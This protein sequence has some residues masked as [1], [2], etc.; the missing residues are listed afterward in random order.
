MSSDSASTQ[1][2]SVSYGGLIVPPVVAKVNTVATTAATTVLPGQSGQTFSLASV[3]AT[4]T[5]PTAAQGKGCSYSFV[6][7]ANNATTAWT[8]AFPAS[9]VYG[10]AIGGP[11]NGLTGLLITGSSNVLFAT[12]ALK[13]DR[14]DCSCDG[15]IWS[16]RAYGTST[17]IATS[18]SV[19]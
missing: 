7:L 18:F 19:S 2:G 10:I 8:I 5:M 11:A 16:V 14:L 4:V 6:L 1:N 15:T 9:T 12:G 3:G 13:G 17:A